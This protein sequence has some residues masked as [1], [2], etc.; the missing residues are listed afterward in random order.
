MI[1]LVCE[2]KDRESVNMSLYFGE[3]NKKK[4]NFHG[5]LLLLLIIND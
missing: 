3:K 1:F 2:R 4:K 5:M